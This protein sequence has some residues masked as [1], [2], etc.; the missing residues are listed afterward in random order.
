VRG[1]ADEEQDKKQVG[2]VAVLHSLYARAGHSILLSLFKSYPGST[3]DLENTVYL[4]Q[5]KL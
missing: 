2:K 4:K 3:L 5:V 1:H